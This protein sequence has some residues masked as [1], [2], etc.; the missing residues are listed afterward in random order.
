M[1]YYH[2]FLEREKNLKSKFSIV[3][4]IGFIVFLSI[5]FIL[6]FMQPDYDASEK[7]VSEFILGEYG[8]L[9]NI[10]IIGNL[11]GCGAFT[12]AF[13]YFH[14]SQKSLIC[15][16]CLCVV[17]LSVFTNF[18]PTDVQG[19]AVTM[20]GHMHNIGVFIGTFAMFP[21][22]IIF[23]FQLKKIGMLKGISSIFIFRSSAC[24]IV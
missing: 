4:I 3:A 15:L 13:Y 11:I 18:F 14:K 16:V 2:D 20:S 24:L 6:H 10:A 1:I 5:I 9:L 7:Y 19:K 17:T 12:I 21:V 8:W 22:M 23:P